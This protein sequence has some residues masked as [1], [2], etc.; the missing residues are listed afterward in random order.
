MSCMEVFSSGPGCHSCIMSM[1]M[2]RVTKGNCV[3]SFCLY[4]A[5]YLK[6][7]TVCLCS[8]WLYHYNALCAYTYMYMY[9]YSSH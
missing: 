5:N 1:T 2:L 4:E 8:V 6:P 9:M 3:H 7:T